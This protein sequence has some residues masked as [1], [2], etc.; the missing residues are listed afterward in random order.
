MSL[1]K[2]MYSISKLNSLGSQ[3]LIHNEYLISLKKNS[4]MEQ[5]E[6][7]DVEYHILTNDEKQSA[8][9]YLSKEQNK[10]IKEFNS[11]FIKINNK[12][13]HNLLDDYWT[14]Y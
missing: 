5:M 14:K 11:E 7:R 13:N 12:W 6:Q 2:I 1:R 3:I 10:R 9:Q 8:I 4:Y